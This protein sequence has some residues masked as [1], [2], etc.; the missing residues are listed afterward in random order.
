MVADK[1][2]FAK[3]DVGYYANPKWFKVERIMRRAMPDALPDALL[4]ALPDALHLAV[5]HAVRTAQALHSAS[6]YYCR[7]HDT[8]GVF[9]VEA[10]KRIV[11]IASAEEE[12]A[13]T[14]LFE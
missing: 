8:D 11:G 9:P 7:E 14:A 13:V 6:I 4:R 12:L 10:V 3:M 1:R 5:R 2:F